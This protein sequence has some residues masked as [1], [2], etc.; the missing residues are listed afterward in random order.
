MKKIILLILFILPQVIY[1]A[2]GDTV[3]VQTF[4]FKDL[5]KRRGVF[6]FP[7]GNERWA[8]IVMVRTLKCDWDTKHDKYP[9]GEWDYTTNTLVYVPRYAG[10]TVKEIFELENFVTPYGKRLDLNG[11]KGWS[12]FYDVTD[13]APLLKGDV[14]LS[15]G[16]LQELLD[17]KFIFIKGVPAR[18][19]IALENVY[20]WGMYKYYDLADNKKLS[21]KNLVIRKDAKGYKLKAR[22]TGHRE[23]GPYACCEW[24]SK[25]MKYTYGNSEGR[26]V[27][28]YWTVWKDC[29]RNPVYPQGGTWPFDRA[30]W[31][32][33]SPAQTFEFDISNLFNPGDTIQNFDYE[34][35]PY[36]SNGE[37]DGEFVE[38]HQIVFYGPPNF[39]NDISIDEIIAPNAYEGYRRDN[40]ICGSPRVIIKNNGSNILQSAK[41][42]YGLSDGKKSEF[43]WSGYLKFLETQE[44]YLPVPDWSWV[45]EGST[46]TAEAVNP[47]NMPD[48]N[49]RNNILAS[50]VSLP[51]EL[52]GKF[53]L[54]IEANDL[55]R[56]GENA[57]T[58]FDGIGRIFMERKVFEDNA[59]YADEI[60]LPGGCYVFLLTDKQ[61]DG[62]MKHWWERSHPERIGK[63]GR[64]FITNTAGDTLQKFPSDFG[65]ELRFC[66]I[67][68]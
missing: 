45:S 47:N 19:V 68:K 30:G 57:Y 6:Q 2:A 28:A 25:Q 37:K 10:D 20:P 29:S 50:T 51:A 44:V 7:G 32:P 59:V 60:N 53:I 4:T 34:I 9:C 42:I 23:V 14:D 48:E 52:P 61:R 11:E 26:M 31:C 18:D 65:A 17:M 39:N 3:I 36:S 15:S 63:N 38:S 41:I 27:I 62:M 21:T 40:P 49:N 56:A 13:Y 43:Q 12:Y 8:K 46:F 67:I 54:N 66:F 24:D 22:I 16:N 58:I 1:S 64:I 35:Q 55:G 5:Y 33:G